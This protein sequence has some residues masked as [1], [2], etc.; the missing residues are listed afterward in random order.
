V[1]VD[2]V[3]H[4][5]AH[6]AADLLETGHA[7]ELGHAD[8]HLVAAIFADEPEAIRNQGLPEQV[9][10]ARIASIRSIRVSK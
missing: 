6:E 9:P 8:A 5:L 7:V 1:A 3:P 2:G 10:S 4:D